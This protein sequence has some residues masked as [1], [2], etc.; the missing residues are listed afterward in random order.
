MTQRV[1]EVDPEAIVACEGRVVPPARNIPPL[2]NV[3]LFARDRNTCLYCGHEH[4]DRE[5]TRDHVVPKSR[6]GGDSWD[7]VVAACRRCNHR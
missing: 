6:G 1:A 3:A 2:T 4:L 5:L 7:N